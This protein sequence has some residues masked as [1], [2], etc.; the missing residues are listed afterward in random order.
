MKLGPVFIA[1]MTFALTAKKPQANA[2]PVAR[3]IVEKVRAPKRVSIAAFAGTRTVWNAKTWNIAVAVMRISVRTTI[4][5][6]TAKL[7][8]LVTVV[9]VGRTSDAQFALRRA[10][11]GVV[12]K[13]KSQPRRQ[14]FRKYYIA[15]KM[16]SL[17]RPRSR[18]DVCGSSDVRQSMYK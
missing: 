14:D 16:T 12:A 10:T 13:Q 11:K 17:D 3:V 18:K 1:S 9:C 2:M 8:T 6:L 5:W 7:A 4:E 15:W